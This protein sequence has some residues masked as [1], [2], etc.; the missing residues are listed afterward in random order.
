M[1]KTISLLILF[2][3]GLVSALI[4]PFAADPIDPFAPAGTGVDPF[5]AD[6]PDPF[7]PADANTVVDPFAAE[8]PDPFA[9]PA[10][11]PFNKDPF[12]PIEISENENEKESQTEY[13]DELPAEKKRAVVIIE[14]SKGIGTGFVSKI[15]GILFIV[16]NVHLLKD[17]DKF[18]FTTM[19]GTNLK[20]SDIY[21]AKGY[22]VAILRILEQ[23][24]PYF[25]EVSPDVFSTVSVGTKILIPGNSMGDGTILQT[26]GEIVSI[27]PK[28]I[29]HDAPT[30]TGNSGSPIL[31]KENWEVIGVDTL[32]IK[33]DQPEWFNK[34]S[35]EDKDSQIKNDV[36]LFGYRIDNIQEWENIQLSELNRQSKDIDEIRTEA[37]S[38]ISAVGGYNW[39]YH[40]DAVSRI[41]N[42][43]LESTSNPRQTN[44]NYEQHKKLRLW[45]LLGHL[46]SLEKRAISNE[47]SAYAL[48]REDY[49]QTIALCQELVIL[50]GRLNK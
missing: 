11:N 19:D 9:A 3:C 18:E 4:D 42:H 47:G 2:S 31:N 35:K 10:R 38:V 37:W 30:F 7:A 48:M 40:S 20:V 12:S 41:D 46:E 13:V 32:A 34:F 15:N 23:D 27:G 44:Q 24:R 17:N 26:E 43:F 36:R 8:S 6:P 22:D 14:G 16:S 49:S 25:F 1:K 50:V 5:A 39:D 28:R 29:E 21:A 45:S 33:R